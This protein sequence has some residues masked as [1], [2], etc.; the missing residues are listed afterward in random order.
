MDAIATALGFLNRIDPLTLDL[1]IKK[2]VTQQSLEMPNY[3]AM[4]CV[5]CVYYAPS[6][7]QILNNILTMVQVLRS[8]IK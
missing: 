1:T 4:V 6:M 7:V 2:L 3:N 5:M 8:E